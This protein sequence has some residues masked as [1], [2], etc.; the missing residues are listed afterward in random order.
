ML[1]PISGWGGLTLATAPMGAFRPTGGPL[2]PLRPA[3]IHWNAE[4][5]TCH[6]N[7]S[8]GSSFQAEGGQDVCLML[9]IGNILELETFPPKFVL[10]DFLK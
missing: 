6:L 9:F 1:P 8:D 2:C 3:T 5:E 10:N 7:L 4:A